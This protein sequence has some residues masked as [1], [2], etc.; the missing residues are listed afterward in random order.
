MC[1]G[2]R[3][4]CSKVHVTAHPISTLGRPATLLRLGLPPAN[5]SGLL[6]MKSGTLP[7]WQ[8]A[9]GYRGDMRKQWRMD[10]TA[11]AGANDVRG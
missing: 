2:M 11:T 8:I 3:G 9:N 4:F 7:F 1:N 10:Q 6:Q 5:R